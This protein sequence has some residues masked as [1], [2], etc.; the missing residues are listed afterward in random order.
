MS[1]T[2]WWFHAFNTVSAAVAPKTKGYLP[3]WARVFL[4][5]RAANGFLCR[6]AFINSKR[7]EN[8]SFNETS[9]IGNFG[10]DENLGL[11]QAFGIY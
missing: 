4:T 11:L 8:D 3:S 1:V 5:L 9:T 10:I 7:A 6:F 2:S